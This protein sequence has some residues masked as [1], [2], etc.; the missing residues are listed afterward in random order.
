[1]FL[2]QRLRADLEGFLQQRQGLL[3]VSLFKVE[4][5]EVA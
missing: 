4:Q 3:V 5:A 1:M 2:A